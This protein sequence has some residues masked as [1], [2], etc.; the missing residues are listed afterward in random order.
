MIKF[1]IPEITNNDKASVNRVCKTGWISSKG[2]T[3]SQF[4]KD[5][6]SWHKMKFALAVSNCTVALHLSLL[7]AD[8]KKGDEV[9]CTNLTWI[10]PANMILLSGAK[11]VLLDV[12]KENFTMNLNQIENKITKKT[13]AILVVHPFGCPVDMIKIMKIAKKYNLKVIEDVAEAI[14][15]KFKKRLC[16]TFGHLSCFSFFANKIITTG[17][18]GMILTNSKKTYLKAKLLRDHGMTEE[19]KYFHKVLGFNYR[20]TAMQAALGSSQLRRLNKIIKKRQKL[21]K[22]YHLNLKDKLSKYKIFREFSKDREP[23]NW[24]VTIS[25]KNSKFRDNL[26]QYLLANN[27]ETRPMIFPVSFAKH[28]KNISKKEDALV[29]MKISLSSLHLPSFNNIT[30]NQIKYVCRKILIWS[31]K[32]K[33]AFYK[34]KN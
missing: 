15:A 34:K 28:I 6:A 13:R 26:M 24:F 32:N 20:M 10:S 9:I 7:A 21:E 23:V 19:K 25:L 16:G 31:K 3:V 4:E 8:I 11:L 5:F 12:E 22:M 14:G 1:F 33:N 2:P 17:E 30:E 27:I 29:S 18:G